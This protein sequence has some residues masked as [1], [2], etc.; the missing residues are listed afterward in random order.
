MKFTKQQLISRMD[1]IGIDWLIADGK[2][3]YQHG[4]RLILKRRSY[5]FFFLNEKE[6][7]RFADGLFISKYLKEQVL[8]R[9]REY[10]QGPSMRSRAQTSMNLGE[11]NNEESSR[12]RNKSINLDDFQQHYHEN[13][14][15]V[16]AQH[17]M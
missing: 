8:A 9:C 7:N 1:I 6:R 11:N 4:V 15:S 10:S 12:K 14:S 3:D 17:E 16:I 13:Y 2:L 5:E